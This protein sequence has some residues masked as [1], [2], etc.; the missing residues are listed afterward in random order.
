MLKSYYPIYTE[1]SACQDCYKCVRECPVKAIKIERGHAEIIQELCIL[2]GRCVQVCPISAKKIRNDINR[3]KQLLKLKEK[4]IVSL[5]PSFISEF[6]DITPEQLIA[7]LKKLGFYGVS[8]TALGA[9]QVSAFCARL[10]ESSSQPIL[11]SSACPTVVEFI[12]K[13]QTD[14]AKYI[15]GVYSP[16]LAHCKLLK[17][18]YGHDI[19]I[20]F[21]GPCISKK[22]EADTHPDLLNISI[23]FK[24]LKQWFEQE[25]IMLAEL[26]PD[27]SDV[28]I[29]RK[30]QEGALYPVDGGMIAGIK[31]NC[32][33]ITPNFMSISG[34]GNI[35]KAL[36]NLEDSETG[37]KIFLEL[38]ACEGGCI[39][40]PMSKNNSQT[41]LK[42]IKVINYAEYPAG[43]IPRKAEID[44][45]E[46]ISIQEVTQNTYGESEIR[47]ALQIVGKHTSED[48]LNCGACGYNSCREFAAALLEGKAE[49]PMCV[50]YMRKLA[51][52]KANALIKTMPSGVVIIDQ[53]LK[54]IECNYLFAQM[55]GEETKQIYEV[56]PGLVGANFRKIFPHSELF[57][58]VLETGKDISNKKITLKNSVLSVSIFTI[59]ENKIVGGI[60]EDITTTTVKKDMIVQKSKD[61]IKKNLETVQ[62]IAYLL[63]ENAS[64]TEII[65]N[66]II[67]GFENDEE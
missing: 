33:V 65:L 18:I 42:R 56:Q 40:G 37:H 21:V 58:E 12:T 31:A 50:S 10:F 46:E 20:V 25:N 22:H 34:I 29:P 59:E 9:E 32:N 54:I 43:Q 19:G 7:G 61:V 52:R 3:V 53:G 2:C 64:E 55:M 15:T 35:K 27:E 13:Y 63:G 14:L 44:I 39:N 67:D 26:K 66:S 51:Q 16:L 23:T 8:E 30:A 17:N 49:Q 5:A 62:K 45:R 28:F 4:V 1:E 41:V 11:I 36:E 60:F 57:R 6:Q 24:Y 48:E 38:L 47:Q